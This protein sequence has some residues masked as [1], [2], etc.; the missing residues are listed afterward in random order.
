M[1]NTISKLESLSSIN[2]LGDLFEKSFPFY[3]IIDED[4]KILL[5]G[6]SM[7]KFISA[8][9]Q[10]EDAFFFLRPTFINIKYEFSSFHAIVDQLVILT[11]KNKIDFKL[12]GTF[13]LLNKNK[14]IFL[15]SPWITTE[16]EL[17]LYGLNVDDF[18]I[19]DCIIDMIMLS[20]PNQNYIEE[21]KKLSVR[22]FESNKLVEERNLQIENFF[23]LSFDFMCIAN[24]NGYFI[25]VNKTFIN[26]LGYDESDLL[27]NKF[28][29]FIHPDDSERTLNEIKKLSLGEVTI[30]FENRYRKNNGDYLVLNWNVTPDISTGLLYATA[31]DMT[32]F[33]QE[34]KVEIENVR[35]KSQELTSE[36]LIKRVLPE[37]LA[38]R[39]MNGEYSISDY[40][41][42]TSILFAD[43]CKF[44]LLIEEMPASTILDLMEIVFSKFDRII[45]KY[46]CEK[47]KTI[48]DGYLA[49]SGAPIFNENHAEKI[50]MAAIEMLEPIE[51]P[52]EI[53]DYF[54]G[55]VEF[56]VRIGIHTGAVVGCVLPGDRMHWDIFSKAVNIAARMEEKSLPGRIH[57]SAEFVKH[58]KNRIALKKVDLKLDFERRGE[59][60]IKNLGKIHTYFINKAI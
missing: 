34:Q 45:N 52:K 23:D 41:P 49:I 39:M 31:R 59:M 54:P 19:S 48:G 29:E 27:K 47:I 33:Y 26:G 1:K 12:R 43:I 2:H 22:L 13:R 37:V 9:D 10:F 17:D 28:L 55:D 56:S 21:L 53:I 6:R 20:K 42:Q 57:V 4:L 58:I 32:L 44:S 36:A 15:G 38:E 25:K 18:D 51:L 35:L 5:A 14:I 3:F 16:H 8:N 50:L 60:E 11:L 30:N 46:G 24:T 7:K 40:Y